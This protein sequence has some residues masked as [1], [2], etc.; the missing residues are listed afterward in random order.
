MYD[1]ICMG[2]TLI[3]NYVMTILMRREITMVEHVIGEG[4]GGT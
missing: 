2:V 4:V 1:G 3:K